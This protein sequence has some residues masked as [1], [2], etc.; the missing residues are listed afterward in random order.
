MTQPTR[1]DVDVVPAADSSI[2]GERAYLGLERPCPLRARSTGT[3]RLLAVTNGLDD[4]G[5]DLRKRLI[6][7]DSKSP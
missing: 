6:V 7:V 1:T 3:Q 2:H 4:F 5:A